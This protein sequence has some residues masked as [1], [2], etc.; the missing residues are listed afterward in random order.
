[1]GRGKIRGLGAG[2]IAVVYEQTDIEEGK[3]CR[4]AQ[5]CRTYEAARELA[6]RLNDM[7]RRTSPHRGARQYGIYYVKENSSSLPWIR[8]EMFSTHADVKHPDEVAFPAI[9]RDPDKPPKPVKFG[10]C[11][12]CKL[13]RRLSCSGMRSTEVRCHPCYLRDRRKRLNEAK[14]KQ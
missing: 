4:V 3:A 7:L 14:A 10:L 12:I 11:P 1:M 2:T 6:S 8:P 5:Y 9:K 13:S